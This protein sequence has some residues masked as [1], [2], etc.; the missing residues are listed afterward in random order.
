[1]GGLR[2]V[3]QGL[4]NGRV[5]RGCQAWTGHA[6]GGGD[7]CWW[8]RALRCAHQVRASPP[9]TCTQVRGVGTGIRRHRLFFLGFKLPPDGQRPRRRLLRWRRGAAEQQQQEQEQRQGA[10]A[11]TGGAASAAAAAAVDAAADPADLASP[12]WVDSYYGAYAAPMP[13]PHLPPRPGAAPAAAGSGA[14]SVAGGSPAAARV[15]RKPTSVRLSVTAQPGSSQGEEA[16]EGE[17]VA[18]ERGRVESLWRLWC[19]GSARC[20]RCRLAARLWAAPCARRAVP[21]LP[22]FGAPHSSLPPAAARPAVRSRRRQRRPDQPPPAAI[23]LRGLRKVFPARDGNAEKVRARA[24]ACAGLR[25]VL[26]GSSSRRARRTRLLPPPSPTAASCSTPRL[27]SPCLA[28]PRCR[29]VA[30]ANLSLA[31]PRSECFGLLGPNGAPRWAGRRLPGGRVL[32]GAGSAGWQREQGACLP[33]CLP[34]RVP[35]RVPA[36]LLIPPCRFAPRTRAVPLLQARARPP[37]SA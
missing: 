20:A 21:R 9:A 3:M 34:A 24:C 33:A 37:P 32:R 16:A 19:V 27:A 18:A 10:A 14:S 36:H 13:T 5:D 31:I 26:T 28:L 22:L 8:R 15:P 30:V 23:M 6:A 35:A 1:M 17:D 29:Q 7:C 2:T 12:G 4:R 25:V 11:A